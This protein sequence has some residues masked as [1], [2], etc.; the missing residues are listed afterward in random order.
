MLRS[1]NLA[2]RELARHGDW[3]GATA[4][5]A[6]MRRCGGVVTPD[7]TTYKALLRGEVSSDKWCDLTRIVA[8]GLLLAHL[9][10]QLPYLARLLSPAVQLSYFGL[11]PA[12]YGLNLFWFSRICTGIARVLRGQADGSPDGYA[13]GAAA[14]GAKSE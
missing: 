11:L 7:L 13:R 12:V 6:D 3:E 5:L 4:L 8:L 2:L 9:F 10:S 1:Y 14:A